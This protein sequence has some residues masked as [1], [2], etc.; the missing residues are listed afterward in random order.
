[1]LQWRL[2]QVCLPTQELFPLRRLENNLNS[3]KVCFQIYPPPEVFCQ[4]GKSSLLAPGNSLYNSC[5][6]LCLVVAIGVFFCSLTFSLPL[7]GNTKLKSSLSVGVSAWIEC[8][9]NIPSVCA[10]YLLVF[11]LLYFFQH[12]CSCFLISTAGGRNW[13]VPALSCETAV[14]E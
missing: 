11:F 14:A 1:M 2:C 10:D 6:E 3:R 5:N 7:W 12:P 4:E 13:P 8:C 9:G